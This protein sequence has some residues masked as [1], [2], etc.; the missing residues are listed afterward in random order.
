MNIYI[1]QSVYP[2]MD[3]PPVDLITVQ[4]KADYVHRICAAWE[5]GVHPEPKTFELFSTWRDVFDQFPLSASCAYHA[6]RAWFGWESVPYPPGVLS[7]TPQWE[8]ADQLE[9][10]PP[11]PCQNMI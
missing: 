1:D 11:D 3:H 9:G 2:E 5:F 6:F 8:L 10:R 4:D 7:P